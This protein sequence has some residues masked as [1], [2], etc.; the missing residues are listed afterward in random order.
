MQKPLGA[1]SEPMQFAFRFLRQTIFGEEI[2]KMMAD[3]STN[4]WRAR[5]YGMLS[6]VRAR[7]SQA[8]S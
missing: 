7:G 3:P 4:V 8:V 5:M 1:G 2:T 6:V